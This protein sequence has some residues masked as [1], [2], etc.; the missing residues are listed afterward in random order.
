MYKHRIA[1]S[2]HERRHAPCILL[3]AYR[4]LLGNSHTFHGVSVGIDPSLIRHAVLEVPIVY[5]WTR[6]LESVLYGKLYITW[7]RASY[8]WHCIM[9]SDKI[10]V[11]TATLLYV[12][13]GSATFQSLCYLD[14]TILQ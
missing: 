13:R 10:K 4:V 5:A 12:E 9:V 1:A 11:T 2:E 8:T 3:G 6:E 7:I 14:C